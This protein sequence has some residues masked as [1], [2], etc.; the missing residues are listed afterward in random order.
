MDITGKIILSGSQSNYSA[1][2]TGNLGKASYSKLP[3]GNYDIV[4]RVNDRQMKISPVVNRA[5]GSTLG[6]FTNI[7]LPHDTTVDRLPRTIDGHMTHYRG[8]RVHHDTDIELASVPIPLNNRLTMDD[9]RG[10]GVIDPSVAKINYTANFKKQPDTALSNYREDNSSGYYGW[11]EIQGIP[12][13]RYKFSGTSIL[14]PK[15]IEEDFTIIASKTRYDTNVTW[16]KLMKMLS[17][18]INRREYTRYNFR[19][20]HIT[21]TNLDTNKSVILNALFYVHEV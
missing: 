17:G 21:I 18:P 6:S 11:W 7:S 3:T 15:P 13:G 1:K 19:T 2:L 16:F 10:G 4:F 20:N 12:P 9:R 14:I 5:G 8:L